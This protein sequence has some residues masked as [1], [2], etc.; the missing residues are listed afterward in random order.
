MLGKDS[1]LNLIDRRKC[2]AVSDWIFFDRS[3][4]DACIF[5]YFVCVPSSPSKLFFII[6]FIFN[7]EERYYL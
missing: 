1:G 3:I 4:V 5:F 2:N 7:D 6:P